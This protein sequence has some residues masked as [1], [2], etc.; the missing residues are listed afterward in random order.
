MP[1]LDSKSE[2]LR[3]SLMPRLAIIM[4]GLPPGRCWSETRGC[5]EK[6]RHA[7]VTLSVKNSQ[8]SSLCPAYDQ[9]SPPWSSSTACITIFRL[10][11]LPNAVHNSLSFLITTGLYTPSPSTNPPSPTLS[12]IQT[13]SKGG[14]TS[15]PQRTR[16]YRS[17]LC[18]ENGH[19][20]VLDN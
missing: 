12:Q 18:V 4:I 6:S 13:G 14:R 19:H 7:S 2:S 3:W 17:L 20:S 1:L 11:Y 15:I 8:R 5:H 10:L 9:P 16:N